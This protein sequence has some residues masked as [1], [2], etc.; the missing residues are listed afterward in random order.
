MAG[1][2]KHQL[3][4]LDCSRHGDGGEG[5]ELRQTE[6]ARSPPKG[7]QFTGSWAGVGGRGWVSPTQSH[8]GSACVE[9]S[10]ICE[11]SAESVL[12][13]LSLSLQSVLGGGGVES[14]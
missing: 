14:Q 9:M 8:C 12:S 6:R 5:V 10:Y 1:E 2:L 11:F 4:G 7:V 3:A 13:C